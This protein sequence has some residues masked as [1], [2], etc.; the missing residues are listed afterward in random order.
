MWL[1]LCLRQVNE[2]RAQKIEVLKE[3]QLGFTLGLV[4]SSE[5]AQE[6]HSNNHD[7]SISTVLDMITR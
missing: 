7:R 2:A 5:S 6:T 1:G 4:P 3:S